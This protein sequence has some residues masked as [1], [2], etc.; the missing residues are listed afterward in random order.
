MGFFYSSE[1]CCNQFFYFELT[2]VP[3]SCLKLEPKMKL[4]ILYLT[5]VVMSIRFP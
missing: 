4:Y 3:L 1:S 5:N 2:Q